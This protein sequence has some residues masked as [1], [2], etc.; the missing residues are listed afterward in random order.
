ME[1]EVHGSEKHREEIQEGKR[2]RKLS[3]YRIKKQQQSFGGPGN[4][5]VFVF[6]GGSCQGSRA[7]MLSGAPVTKHPSTHSSGAPLTRRLISSCLSGADLAVAFIIVEVW[8]SVSFL[9]QRCPA[10]ML[11]T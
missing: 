11:Q 8:L 9:M 2:D 7:S 5:S 4:K 6:S 10:T 3:S 1:D